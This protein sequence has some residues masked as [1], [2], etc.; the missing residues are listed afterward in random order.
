MEHAAPSLVLGLDR[1]PALAHPSGSPSLGV[2]EDVRV[3][4]NELLV[5]GARDVVEI[6]LPLLLEQQREEEDL[7]EQVAELVAQLRGLVGERR[8][9]DLVGLFDRV[10]D[11][12]ACGLLAIPRAIGTQAPRSAP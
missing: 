6:A 3:P 8:V 7:E 12:R 2:A 5:H 11:D 4:A 1:L 10:R 9:R